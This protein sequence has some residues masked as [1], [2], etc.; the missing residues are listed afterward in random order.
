MKLL[1]TGAAG[2][3]GRAFLGQ[4]PGHHD[5]AAFSHEELDIGDHHAVMRTVRAVGPDAILNFAAFT[6]VDACEAE[7]GRAVRDNAMGP[8][9]LALAARAAGA[10]LLHVSTDYVFDGG[11]GSPYDELDAPFPLPSIYAR[12]KLAGEE[13]V[14]RLWPEHFIVRTGFVFGGG[15]DYLSGALA[16]LAAGEPAGGIQD[17]IGSPTPVGHLA[18]RLLPLLL[19]GRFGTYH[20]AGPEATSWHD[21]LLR[22]K[23]IGDLPGQVQVQ[24]AADLGLPAPRPRN[25]S[26]TSVFAAEVGLSPFPP[27]D[28]ALGELLAVG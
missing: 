18:T 4:V 12:T 16:R 6:N 3:L 26:L 15:G 9:S 1:V 22:A 21:V 20:L 28:E 17:R 13:Y 27:L 2:R 23:R 25:S 19:T 8:Q 10:V 11:K 5:V 7:A 14:R 24:G